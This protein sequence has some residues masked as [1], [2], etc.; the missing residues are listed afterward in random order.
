MRNGH[1]DKSGKTLNPLASGSPPGP[2][3]LFFCIWNSLKT[4]NPKPY[5]KNHLPFPIWD[6]CFRLQCAS[7]RIQHRTWRLVLWFRVLASVSR[8]IWGFP[9]FGYQVGCKGMNNSFVAKNCG[10]LFWVVPTEIEHT[11]L[12]LI[13]GPLVMETTVE[14]MASTIAS[15]EN[16]NVE[17]SRR[18]NG[19]YAV[20]WSC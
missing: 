20:A 14:I 12:G 18:P 11:V 16:N 7:F 15:H 9:E 8:N 5:V 13:L 2:A 10:I 17:S 3:K 19:Y 4:L 6:L 1:L